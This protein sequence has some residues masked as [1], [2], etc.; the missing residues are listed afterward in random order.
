MPELYLADRRERPGIIFMLVEGR[1]NPV[2]FRDWEQLDGI[3][4]FETGPA[5][6]VAPDQNDIYSTDGRTES[7]VYRHFTYVYNIAFH[8]GSRYFLYFSAAPY[9]LESEGQ[10]FRLNLERLEDPPELFCTVPIDEVEFWGGDFSFD[11]AGNLYI[12]SGNRVPASIYRYHLGHFVEQYTAREPIMG[13]SFM[14][15]DTL[16]YVNGGNLLCRLTDFADRVIEYEGR[17]DA[18]LTDVAYVELPHSA[19]CSIAGNLFGGEED[20]PRTTIIARGPYL[21]WR[22]IEHSLTHPDGG[23]SYELENLLYGSYWVQTE[24]GREEGWAAY[25]PQSRLVPCAS[26]GVDFEMSRE[27]L[28]LNLVSLECND[29]QE[30]TDEVYIIVD[31]RRIWSSSMKTGQVRPIG[32]TFTFHE[33]HRIEVWE[34]DSRKDDR[35]GTFTLTYA[36]AFDLIRDDERPYSHVFHRSR[37]FPGSATYTLIFDIT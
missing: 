8:P 2:Y 32:R 6:F 20:W 13:F 1:L 5:Y 33:D 29:A 12:S 22:R 7:P 15:M 34:E 36:D 3:G 21:F 18:R 23:G 14:D 11:P 10:I 28:V 37:G 26:T 4:I 25:L 9:G 30:A 27:G 24:I 17:E 31:G 35:I 19:P 16:Y